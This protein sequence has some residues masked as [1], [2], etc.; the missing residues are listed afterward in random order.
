MANFT[1]MIGIYIPSITYTSVG[2][3]FV[4]AIRLEARNLYQPEK[5]YQVYT[6]Y[7]STEPKTDYCAYAYRQVIGARVDTPTSCNPVTSVQYSDDSQRCQYGRFYDYIS[8]DPND[9]D[10]GLNHTLTCFSNK[11]KIKTLESFTI[12]DRD[13]IYVIETDEADAAIELIFTFYTLSYDQY[14]HTNLQYPED[15]MAAHSCPQ[16]YIEIGTMTK[17]VRASTLGQNEEADMAAEDELQMYYDITKKDD[18]DTTLYLPVGGKFKPVVGLE[19]DSPKVVESGK[20]IFDEYK[21][22][23]SLTSETDWGDPIHININNFTVASDTEKL[24]QACLSAYLPKALEYTA[25]EAAES[26]QREYFSPPTFVNINLYKHISQP[27]AKQLELHDLNVDSSQ[28][29]WATMPTFAVQNLTY[30]SQLQTNGIVYTPCTILEY[31][32]ELGAVVYDA[33]GITKKFTTIETSEDEQALQDF[34]YTGTSCI[35]GRFFSYGLSKLPHTKFNILQYCNNFGFLRPSDGTTVEAFF[36]KRPSY[37]RNEVDPDVGLYSRDTS[38][39]KGTDRFKGTLMVD[40]YSI[41]ST[42][43]YNYLLSYTTASDAIN[44][45]YPLNAYFQNVDLKDRSHW[46]H[47]YQTNLTLSVIK[48]H[49]NGDQ[50]DQDMDSNVTIWFDANKSAY[51]HVF[52]TDDLENLPSI[53]GKFKIYTSDAF[54][55]IPTLSSETK[56]PIMSMHKRWGYSNTY[57]DTGNF[58][59][60][61]RTQKSPSHRFYPTHDYQ[62]MIDWVGEFSEGN[63]GFYVGN[64]PVTKSIPDYEQKLVLSPMLAIDMDESNTTLSNKGDYRVIPAYYYGDA[65]DQDAVITDYKNQ[66][67]NIKQASG[68]DLKVTSDA[69]IPSFPLST[70]INYGDTESVPQPYPLYYSAGSSATVTV[71]IDRESSFESGLYVLKFQKYFISGDRPELKSQKLKYTHNSKNYTSNYDFIVLMINEDGTGSP[72]DV[73]FSVT[74]DVHAWITNFALYQVDMSNNKNLNQVLLAYWYQQAKS[75]VLGTGVSI[76]PDNDSDPFYKLLY[77]NI[78]FPSAVCAYENFTLFPNV[79]GGVK[80]GFTKSYKAAY[81]PQNPMYNIIGLYNIQ[82]TSITQ[83]DDLPDDIKVEELI[84]YNQPSRYV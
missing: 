27:I 63:C 55:N 33:E 2:P 52:T 1:P 45:I 16:D 62:R 84:C 40:E 72:I 8:S 56:I 43:K 80:P 65:D 58:I 11:S 32:P 13:G 26:D 64:D 75:T 31:L 30:N 83:V 7:P 66:M 50:T 39:F 24:E 74:K 37:L 29:L 79:D 71:Q 46:Q 12:N 17:I 4:D 67:V 14:D 9:T 82:N 18:E 48:V 35:A 25:N 28:M 47:N 61:N 20:T 44:S 19:S 60:T 68:F 10:G 53:L 3:G 76:V 6:Q 15:P 81:F 36:V 21:E 41:D 5:K 77:D 22:T 78:I 42:S 54:V 73:T 38:L 23:G 49:T 59:L 34:T 57:I 51:C 70:F 69:I